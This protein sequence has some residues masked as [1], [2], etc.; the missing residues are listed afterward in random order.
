MIIAFWRYK[1]RPDVTAEDIDQWI[2][3]AGSQGDINIIVKP[4]Y[5]VVDEKVFGDNPM[6]RN[7]FHDV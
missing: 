2:K 4:S 6:T 3:N 7:S 5:N 1:K